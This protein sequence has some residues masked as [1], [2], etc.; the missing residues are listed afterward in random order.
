MA[1]PRSRGASPSTRRPPIR[2]S[3]LVAVSSPATMRSSV[4]LPQPEAPSSTRNSW[5][6]M[7][8]SIVCS[9]V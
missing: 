3:P 9:A 1:M 2:T 5:S 4:V 8:R 6:R 7:V